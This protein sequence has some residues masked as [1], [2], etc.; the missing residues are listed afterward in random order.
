MYKDINIVFN[1]APIN[2]L[3][4]VVV[5]AFVRCAVVVVVIR[6]LCT[7]QEINKK[8]STQPK[9]QANSLKTSRESAKKEQHVTQ[10]SSRA[11]ESE[12]ESASA[13]CV[14]LTFY[15]AACLPRSPA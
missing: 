6:I 15:R 9:G 12:R 7:F 14:L 3:V 13:H 1:S 11:S 5:V 4:I 8:N 2:L 10:N